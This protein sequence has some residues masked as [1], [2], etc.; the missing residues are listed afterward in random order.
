M[1]KLLVVILSATS[2]KEHCHHSV[3]AFE[4]HYMYDVHSINKGPDMALRVA[5][6]F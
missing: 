1:A 2:V 5:N 6:R 3:T 4:H